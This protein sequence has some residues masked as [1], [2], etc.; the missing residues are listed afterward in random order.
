MNWTFQGKEFIYDMIG[1]NYGFVYCITNLVLNKKYIGRKYFYS[2]KTLPPLKGKSRKRKLVLESNWESYWGS[3]EYLLQDIAILGQEN[4]SREILSLHPNKQETNYH[5]TKLQFMLNVLES[6]NENG[7]R[8]YYN[9]NIMTKF[10]PNEKQHSHR[11]MMHEYFT[12][13]SAGTLLEEA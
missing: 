7:E 8:L 10:Y 11:Q 5:E 9:Q 2:T 3:S 4:F 6:R 1:N 12:T 13:Y